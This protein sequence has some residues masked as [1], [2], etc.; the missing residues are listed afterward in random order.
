MGRQYLKSK[1]ARKGF[2]LGTESIGMVIMHNALINISSF[3][4]FPEKY[5]VVFV[6]PFKIDR[7]YDNL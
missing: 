7:T 6:L 3:T 4:V 5:S 2:S 1:E